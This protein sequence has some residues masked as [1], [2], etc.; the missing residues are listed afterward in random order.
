MLHDVLAPGSDRLAHALA[1]GRRAQGVVAAHQ[2]PQPD[3]VVAAAYLH[4]VGYAAAATDTGMHQLDGARYLRGLGYEAD[5]CRLVAH[6]TFALVEARNKGL[7][8]A[9]D[10]EFPR[11]ATLDL[12][13]MLDVVTF[14]DL[15]TSH[16]GHPVTVDERFAG[17]Y[18]RYPA[19]HVVTRTMREVEPLARQAVERVRMIVPVR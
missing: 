17:I 5:L 16:T 8:G 18:T 12:D 1:V 6:H 4:D 13:A 2:F 19:D 9:L 7:D 11:P 3:L 15:T 14:C 10:A